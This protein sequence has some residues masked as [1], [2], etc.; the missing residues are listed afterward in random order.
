[1][2]RLGVAALQGVL[3]EGG[4]AASQC[5][6]DAHEPCC[7]GA[8]CC[9]PC[10]E[11]QY[12]ADTLKWNLHDSNLVLSQC[13]NW[14]W[15]LRGLSCMPGQRSSERGGNVQCE[16]QYSGAVQG[17]GCRTSTRA[18]EAALPLLCRVWLWL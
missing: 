12:I 1:V 15:R 10:W 13:F 11:W 9:V 8:R 3:F 18:A 7:V 2:W 17:Y 16:L 5:A 6:L 4:A 14:R